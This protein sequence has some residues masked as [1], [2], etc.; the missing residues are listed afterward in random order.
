VGLKPSRGRISAGPRFGDIMTGLVSEHVVSRSVRDVAALLDAIHGIA[1]GDPY[2]A[3][4]PQRLYVDELDAARD[5]LRIGLMT[6]APGGQ[7]DVHPDC[8]IAAEDAAGLLESL[9]HNVEAS[10]PKAMDD[11]DYIERFIMRWTVGVAW[12]LDYW[13][14]RTGEQVGPEGVEASTWALAEMGR[15]FTGP[16]YLA[17]LEYQQRTARR[18]AEWWEQGFDLLLTSTMGEPPTPL[19]AFEPEPDNP[20]SPIMRSIPT[21][22]FTAFWNSA[23]PPA[24]SLPLHWS[25]DG[26]P[27]GVQL[28]APYGREDLLIRTAA[29]LEQARPWAGRRPPVFAA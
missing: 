18:A 19:G 15:S 8:V 23:G 17:A 22:A 16:A 24:I 28:V 26:L 7:F 10:Y 11:P 29:Q 14:R 5:P 2:A 21:A 1:P 3:P 4:D 13:S 9:D 12:N 25:D 20:I 6:T 27:I